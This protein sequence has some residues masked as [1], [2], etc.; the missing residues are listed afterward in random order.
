MFKAESAQI[1]AKTYATTVLA[2]E[3]VQIMAKR[4]QLQQQQQNL[5]TS[6]QNVRNNNS[7]NRISTNH[8]KTYA[9][10]TAATEL[11]Q[12]MAK[13][14][15]LVTFGLKGGFDA[16]RQVADNT[17]L[18]SLLANI[19]DTKSLIIHPTSTTHQ[20]LSDEQQEATG[21]TK[22]LI[23]LSVGLEDIEDLKSDLKEA[24]VTIKSTQLV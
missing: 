15:Q 12:I 4:T 10:T 17:K 2:T 20:Q 24:F 14:T 21:V 13:R 7:S 11:V 9:T 8:C 5:Y 1:M 22:D 6:W 19:G 23:R 3:S 16:A 18:F